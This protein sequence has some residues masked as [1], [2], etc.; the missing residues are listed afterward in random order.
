MSRVIARLVSLVVYVAVPVL[1]LLYFGWDWRSVLVLYWLEN[2]TLGL[3]NVVAISRTTMIHDPDGPAIR[4]NGRPISTIGSKGALTGFF[5]LHY[6]L[7]TLVHGV[8][9]MVI[10][11]G[12]FSFGSGAGW[13]DAEPVRW[14][15]VLLIWLVGSAA[16]LA[17]DVLRPR[18]SLPA[19]SRL[20]I[21][22]YGRIAVLHVS[23]IAGVFLINSLNWPPIAAVML[24]AL[25]AVV[26]LWNP[27]AGR[28]PARRSAG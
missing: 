14:G 9:V 6:G 1:G 20:F 27:F 22:P 4:L 25:H 3:R 8:F 10:V 12:F 13:P 2:I 16:Q 28:A 17:T 23:I 7:F 21:G 5:V 18:E 15:M 26:D 24:V 11:A 19:A